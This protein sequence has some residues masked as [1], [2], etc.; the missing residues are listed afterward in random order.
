MRPALLAVPL[1]LLAA[2]AAAGQGPAAP[3]GAA[4]PAAAAPPVARPLPLL[5]SNFE[6]PPPGVPYGGQMAPSIPTGPASDGPATL[7]GSRAWASAEY[8]MWW[9][10]PMNSPDLIQSVSANAALAGGA[11]PPGAAARVFPAT[12]QLEFGA[13]SGIRGTAG[14]AWDHVGV[15]VSGFYLG[16]KTRDGALF[17][18][19]TVFSVARPYISAGSGA[20]TSL[21]SSL[22]GQYVGGTTASVENQLWGLDGNI[23]FPWYA[24]LT[25]YTHGL[26][27]FRYLDLRESINVVSTATFPTGGVIDVRDEIRTRNQFYGGQVGLDGRIGGCEKGL[28]LQVMPKLAMGGVRQSVTYTGSNSA[29]VPGLAPDVQAGGLYAR[30]AALGTFTRDKFAAVAS[31]DL[32]LTYNFNESSQVFFGYSIIWISSV[33]RPGEQID[34]TVNDSRARFVAN[35]TPSGANRPAP[36]FVGNDFWTQGLNFG[37]RLQY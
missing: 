22:A 16:Q 37:L 29:T 33:L 20:A 6:D 14:Y 27:G 15:E 26:A 4:P 34:L 35:P 13:I 5:M 23:R 1:C 9:V 36:Q 18:D 11:L 32:N 21:F 30:D 10:T 2:S 24:Y 25:N 8:L 7:Y 31:L 17:S 12:R 19:G 28:G 3:P